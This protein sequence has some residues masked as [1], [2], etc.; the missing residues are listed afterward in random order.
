MKLNSGNGTILFCTEF[1]ICLRKDSFQTICYYDSWL[2]HALP[3]AK[4]NWL[5]S[6]SFARSGTALAP[7]GAGSIPR[8]LSVLCVSQLGGFSFSFFYFLYLSPLL[9][10][11]RAAEK[12]AWNLAANS[13][14]AEHALEHPGTKP[15]A[16]LSIS[17]SN[18]Q[19]PKLL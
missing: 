5:P 6:L 14:G 12:S 11:S 10:T 2:C 1:F 8:C 17:V 3:W 4:W 19:T 7:K 13:S 15:T 9:S 18:S 16:Y